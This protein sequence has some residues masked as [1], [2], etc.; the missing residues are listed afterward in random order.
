MVLSSVST[1]REC[2]AYLSAAAASA[3]LGNVPIRTLERWRFTGAGPPYTKI[4]RTI[5]YAIVDL[6]QWMARH[7]RTST[8]AP[9]SEHNA[10]DTDHA[11]G[12]QPE[13]PWGWP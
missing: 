12:S 3:Y 2:R 5:R 13:S 10:P 9:N 4:G 6:D 11:P 1:D 7:R 8:S